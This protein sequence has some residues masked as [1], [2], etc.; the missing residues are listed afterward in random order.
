MSEHNYIVFED[1]EIDIVHKCVICEEEFDDRERIFEL[2][3]VRR[4]EEPGGVYTKESMRKDGKPFWPLYCHVDCL[5][6]VRNV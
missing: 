2:S 5:D 4:Y 3:L 6:W 1:L